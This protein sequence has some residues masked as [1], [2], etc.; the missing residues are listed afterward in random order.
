MLV[1]AVKVMFVPALAFV[2]L[3]PSVVA[4]GLVVLVKRV[5]RLC[6]PTVTMSGLP[7][8]SKSAIARYSLPSL[9]SVYL[10][11]RL[12]VAEPELR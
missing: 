8:L 3:A 2:V 5:T 11:S 12:K 1:V 9:V 6:R 10:L 7:L 4:L